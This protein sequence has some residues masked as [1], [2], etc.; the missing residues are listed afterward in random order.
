M[1]VMDASAAWKDEKEAKPILACSCAGRLLALGIEVLNDWDVGAVALALALALAFALAL[2][3]ELVR[4]HAWCTR[5][6]GKEGVS[7]VGFD[8]A[9]AGG[10]A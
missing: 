9:I 6:K 7:R 3:A 2:S 4:M 8:Q 10:G 5:E 1:H